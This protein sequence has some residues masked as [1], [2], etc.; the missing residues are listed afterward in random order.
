MFASGKSLCV[1][2]GNRRFKVYQSLAN[3]G[4]LNGKIPVRVFDPTAPVE[5]GS[6]E[7]RRR[8]LKLRD[9]FQEIKERGLL[10]QRKVRK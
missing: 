10:R 6:A 7:E 2:D 8:R 3:D 1:L 5:G 4:V 9:R